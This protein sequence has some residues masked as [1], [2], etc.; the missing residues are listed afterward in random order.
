M[1]AHKASIPFE[2]A[3]PRTIQKRGLCMV[4]ECVLQ[5]S[6]ATQVKALRTVELV[7]SWPRHQVRGQERGRDAGQVLLDPRRGPRPRAPSLEP[8]HL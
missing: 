4:F 7:V 3:H 8:G 6:A 2:R 1:G 5:S